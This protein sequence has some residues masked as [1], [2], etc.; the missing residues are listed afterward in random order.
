GEHPGRLDFEVQAARADQHRV[1]LRVNVERDGIRRASNLLVAAR[2]MQWRM[3]LSPRHAHRY[4]GY[5]SW[6]RFT[7]KRQVCTQLASRSRWPRHFLPSLERLEKRWLPAVAPSF[8]P[9]VFSTSAHLDHPRRPPQQRQ[10]HSQRLGFAIDFLPREEAPRV[11]PL[12]PIVG[13][14]LSSVSPTLV[15]VFGKPQ[16]S[17]FYRHGPSK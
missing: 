17:P 5:Q 7:W 3:S 9:P 1:G 4:R 12:V 16:S 10:P 14:Q 13:E 15:P 6:F 2:Y 11:T 8:T